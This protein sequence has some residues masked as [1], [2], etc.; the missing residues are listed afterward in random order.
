MTSVQQ[1]QGVKEVKKTEEK[2][3]KQQKNG[4]KI[5]ELNANSN[6]LKPTH[7]SRSKRNYF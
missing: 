3:C 7:S 1:N 4:A 6:L 2:T 5:P